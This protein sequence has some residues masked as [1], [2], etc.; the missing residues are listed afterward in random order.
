M[1]DGFGPAT[2]ANSLSAQLKRLVAPTG[3]LP[4]LSFR[5]VPVK[6]G[7]DAIE[8]SLGPSAA[9]VLIALIAAVFGLG[10]MLQLSGLLSWLR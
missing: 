5:R 6:K 10:E 4:F 9:W 2:R 3:R 8:V 1:P 7:R